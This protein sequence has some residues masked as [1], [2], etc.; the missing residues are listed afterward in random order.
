MFI[1]SWGG[2]FIVRGDNFIPMEVYTSNL[3]VFMSAVLGGNVLIDLWHF[4]HTSAR[5]KNVVPPL[6]NP[7]FEKILISFLTM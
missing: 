7:F 4:L 1:H 6:K 5:K 3:V 2:S